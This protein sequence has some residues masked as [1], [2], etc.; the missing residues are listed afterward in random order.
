[1]LQV[2]D[3]ELTMIRDRAARII[4]TTTDR[5]WPARQCA[6]CWSHLA[7]IGRTRAPDRPLFWSV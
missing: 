1:M 3:D 4:D 6:N 5:L 2:D 7:T